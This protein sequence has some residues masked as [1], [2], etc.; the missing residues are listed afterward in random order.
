M[1]DPRMTRFAE[2]LIDY[3]TALKPGEKILIEAIDIPH[4]MTCELVRVARARGAD[5]IVMLKSNRVQRALLLDASEPQFEL[6]ADV[7]A[8]A[9]SNVQAY[10]GLRGSHNI[11]ELADVGEAQHKIYQQTVWQRVHLEIRVPKTRWVV[12]RWPTS[13]MAQQA[14]LST[15]AFEDFYFNV[16]TLDYARMSDAMQPLGKR[17]TEA[18][19]VRITGPGTNLT[20]SVKGIPAVCCDGKLNIPDGEVFTAPVKDSVNGTLQYNARTTSQGVIH[21][22]IRFVFKDGK[23]VEA[24]SSNTAHL[25]KVLD[26]DPGARYIG[27]FAIGFNPYIHTPML[28]ALF[29]EKIAGSFHFTPGQAYDDADN[30][31]RSTVHWDI[32]CLQAPPHGS[33]EIWFDGELIRKDGKFIPADLQGLNPENLM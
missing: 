16:C 24:T 5:P 30:G 32:V 14:G 19:Q 11:T 8:L 18:D 22:G 15:D 12:V 31:N 13:S 7:E 25:N 28:D 23:I 17:M 21:D 2:V 27:E 29:D 6:M 26:T 1:I 20:F 9:M 3:A 33:G 4:E 10:L